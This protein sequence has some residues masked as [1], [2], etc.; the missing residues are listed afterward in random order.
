[1]LPNIALNVTSAFDLFIVSIKAIVYVKNIRIL[2]INIILL[3]FPHSIINITNGITLIIL[4][5]IRYFSFLWFKIANNTYSANETS[6]PI[7]TRI[8]VS[9][10]TRPIKNINGIGNQIY[11]HPNTI[12]SNNTFYP[13]FFP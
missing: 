5:G 1:M 11:V 7:A 13:L 6:K 8:I 12:S 2:K 9:E 10:L 3:K 4:K